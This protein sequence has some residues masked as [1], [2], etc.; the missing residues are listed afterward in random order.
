MYPAIICQRASLVIT[1]LCYTAYDMKDTQTQLK[2]PKSMWEMVKR[3]GP[4]FVALSIKSGRVVASG[5]TMK[6]V[7][8]HVKHG[9]LFKENK[10][11]IRHVPPPKA[12]LVYASRSDS[13]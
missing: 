3:Y 10:V 2:S 6:E 12:F 4:G 11:R 9:K 8:T 13:F 5:K 7:W 1:A